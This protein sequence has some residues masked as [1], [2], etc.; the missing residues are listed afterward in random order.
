MKAGA[1]DDRFRFVGQLLLLVAA[2]RV[3]SAWFMPDRKDPLDAEMLF[4]STFLLVVH[5]AFYHFGARFR[6]SKKGSV[7][8]YVGIQFTLA[9]AISLYSRSMVLAIALFTALGVQAFILLKTAA[10]GWQKRRRMKP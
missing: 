3:V 7:A 6:A 1:A 5:S 2:L 9:A 4:A 10:G 8:G